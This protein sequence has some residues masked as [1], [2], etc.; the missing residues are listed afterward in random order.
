L[1]GKDVESRMCSLSIFI[2]F[3]NSMNPNSS[4]LV[5]RYYTSWIQQKQAKRGPEDLW[6]GAQPVGFMQAKASQDSLRQCPMQGAQ[7]ES[8]PF[9][10]CP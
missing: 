3:E 10:P 7:L 4:K 9:Q 6:Q 5:T 1:R 8:E 2:K